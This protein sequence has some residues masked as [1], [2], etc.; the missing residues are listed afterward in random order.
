MEMSR[1]SQARWS[2][3]RAR[4]RTHFVLTWGLLFWGGLM[5]VLMGL[6]YP[7]ATRGS[8]ALTA[9]WLMLNAGLWALGGLVFGFATWH[10]SE[11]AYRQSIRSTGIPTA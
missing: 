5:F 8:D 4:G 9:Q 3:R 6:V 11:R 10:F 2:R 7:I 1:N